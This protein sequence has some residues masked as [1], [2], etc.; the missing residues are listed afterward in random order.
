MKK[1]GH[2]L[3]RRDVALV[4]VDKS[5]Q[6]YILSLNQLA[7]REGNYN[8]YTTHLPI[9]LFLVPASAPQLV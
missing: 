2:L 7:G 5:C 4:A 1:I 6:G 8:Y 3:F 9:E